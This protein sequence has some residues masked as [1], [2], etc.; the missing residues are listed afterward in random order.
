MDILVR[1][2]TVRDA[3]DFAYVICESWKVAYKDIVA[4]DDLERYTNVEW[5]ENLFKNW[6]QSDTALFYMAVDGETPC[7]ICAASPSRDEDMPGFGEVVAIYT[8]EAYW[9]HGVGKLLMDAALT[10]LKNQGFDCA[11]LWAF[12]ANGRGRGFYEKYGFTFGDICKD[13]RFANAKEVRYTIKL[14]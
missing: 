11:M 4:P 13:S 5:R 12:E 2:A 14:V 1:K 10:G 3:Y 9:G 6:M 7:G 8:L